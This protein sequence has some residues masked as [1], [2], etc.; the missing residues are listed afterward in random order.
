MKARLRSPHTLCLFPRL[1]C[2]IPN[3]IYFQDLFNPDH[4]DRTLWPVGI[5]RVTS[6]LFPLLVF[7]LLL[8]ITEDET[9]CPVTWTATGQTPKPWTVRPGLLFIL[10][11]KLKHSIKEWN[12]DIFLHFTSDTFHFINTCF[13]HKYSVKWES[14]WWMVLQAK[15]Y[16]N[17][18][19][20]CG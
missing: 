11:E 10:L 13:C 12:D 9:V 17:S 20:F 1:F 15:H 6:T 2:Y 3:P 18:L 16:A 19:Q 5:I 4:Q 14:H 7:S 8:Q